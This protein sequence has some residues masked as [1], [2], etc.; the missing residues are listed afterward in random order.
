MKVYT[1]TGDKGATS[2]IGGKR[3]P[4]NHPRIEAYGT[5]DELMAFVALLRD[6]EI[7]ASTK[8]FLAEVLDRLMSCASVLAADCD[9]CKVKIPLIL[10]SDIALIEKEID[11]MDSVLPPLASF[12]LPGG[13]QAVSLCHVARTICRRAERL[14]IGVAEH[15]AIPENLIIFIN[16]LSDY[17]FVLSRKLAKDLNILQIPWKPRV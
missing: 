15:N 6:Q 12:V 14:A 4:K 5:V 9:D 16:R 13:H 17:F 3:V 8:A 2:L 10:D 7:D 11:A 1:K